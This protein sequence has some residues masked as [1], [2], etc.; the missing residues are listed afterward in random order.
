MFVFTEFVHET[1]IFWAFFH[2]PLCSGEVFG[3]RDGDLQP[4]WLIP[5]VRRL[6][7]G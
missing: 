6:D 7:R 2:F 1:V 4:Q 5:E 3:H